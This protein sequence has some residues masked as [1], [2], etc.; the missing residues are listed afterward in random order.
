LSPEAPLEDLSREELIGLIRELARQ[1]T[2]LREEIE[3]LKRSGHRSAAP[4]SKGKGKS[5][6]KPPGR[7]P[8]QGY[9]RFRAAPQQAP[10]EVITAEVPAQCP[11]C[12]GKLDRV[13]EEWA[14]TTDVVNPQPRVRGYRVPVCRC[15]KCGKPVRGTAPGLAP[16]QVGATAHRLGPGVKAAAHVLHYGV[17]VPVRKVPQVLKELTGISVTQ[18]ALTQDALRQAKGKIAVQY[19]QLRTSIATAPVVHTDDTGWR[20]SGQAAF[21]MGFDSDRATVYQ[22]RPRH[23]HEEV[24]EVVPANYAGVLVNDRGKSYDAREL[25]DL[26]QQKC[27]AH[28]LRNISEVV[29]RKCGMARQFGLTLKILLRQGIALWKARP[30]LSPENYQAG[31]KEL[32]DQLTRHLRNR[33]LRDDDNQRL[34]NGIGGQN[35]RGHLLRFLL[36]EGVEPTNNRAERILRPAVIARKVSHCS[37]NRRGAEAFS[38]FVSV[39]QTARKNNPASLTQSLLVCSSP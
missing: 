23:R 25:E 7:K 34:L 18:S 24:L 10:Q 33:I 17:G 37:K 39:L 35:D 19:Q 20:V 2:E 27:L 22:I 3:R 4:F 12:G 8:G 31:V 9:F 14:T 6:P 15:R 21:L 26:H 36:Q 30:N 11:A 28:L 38:A 5:N 16:D 13:G 1:N 29:E 32:A